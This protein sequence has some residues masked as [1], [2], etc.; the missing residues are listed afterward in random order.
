MYHQVQ[1][2]TNPTFC[3]H[4]LYSYVV[5]ISEQTAIISLYNI[6]WLVFY[7]RDSVCLLRGT[8]IVT[9][10]QQTQLHGMTNMWMTL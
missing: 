6:N 8:L 10:L 3:P 4:Y 1:P 7:N 2:S 5:W 9:A